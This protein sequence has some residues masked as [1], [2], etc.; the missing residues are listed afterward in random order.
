MK[1]LSGIIFFLTIAFTSVA[2]QADSSFVL[3]TDL[4]TSLLIC[5]PGDNFYSGF[6]HC[7][8]RLQCPSHDL[9]VTFTY[10]L[11]DN[12]ANR[13]AMFR[14]NG[15]GKYS[16]IKTAAFLEEY[17]KEG[18]GVV[19]YPVNISVEQTRALWQILDSENASPR[20]RQYNFLHTN[21]S[22]MCFYALERVMK[23]EEI[24]WN[25]LTEGCTGT[26]RN[27]VKYV[28]KGRPW[29]ELFWSTILGSTGEEKG[30]LEDKLAPMLVEPT[31]DKAIIRTTSGTTRPFI[32]GE[33]TR[34][35]EQ[36][37]TYPHN[38]F[39]PTLVFALLL[40]FAVF[41]S[42]YEWKRGYK[43]LPRTFDTILLAAQT[44][45]GLFIFYLSCLSHMVGAAHNWNLLIFNPLPLLLWICFRRCKWFPKVYLL[46]SI[47]I[48]LYI[49]SWAFKPSV[50]L[51]LVLVAF[52]F[53]VR[54]LARVVLSKKG[55]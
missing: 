3:P 47:V 10:S 39:T 46:Y 26:Y 50:T 38:P 17:V 34:L 15:A 40:V 42:I 53:L 22:S 35:V 11:D 30:Q 2:Q 48:L 54:T 21:C 45:V 28:S 23:G 51:P 9:D 6:G 33:P 8:L 5:Q 20:Y 18:R 25:G 55:N 52:T 7:A 24:V 31:I 43:A 14:G 13:I 41:V 36:T 29:T 4:T 32:Q 37:L 12:L 27:F 19:D 49:A 44:L 1:R 16:S